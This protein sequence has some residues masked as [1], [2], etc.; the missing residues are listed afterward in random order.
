MKK[1]IVSVLTTSLFLVTGVTSLYAGGGGLSGGALEITQQENK[2]LLEESNSVNSNTRD[3][4]GEIL[5]QETVLDPLAN[6]LRGETIKHISDD[7]TQWIEGG[8]NGDDPLII[9]KPKEFIDEG[10]LTVVRKAISALPESSTYSGAAIEALR[11]EYTQTDLEEKI[12]IL[13]KSSI[14]VDVYNNMC[15]EKKL[16]ELAK[17]RARDAD[18]EYTAEEVTRQKQILYDYACVGDPEDDEH[19]A[20]L[21]DLYH[22]DNSLGGEDAFYNLTVNGD[23]PFSRSEQIKWLVTKDA[24]EEKDRRTRELYGGINAVSE[25]ECTEE[26]TDITGATY[27]SDSVITT[28]SASIQEAYNTSK[29]SIYDYLIGAQGDGYNDNVLG[30]FAESDIFDGFNDGLTTIGT[31]NTSSID[32]ASAPPVEDLRENNTYRLSLIR[33]IT[34][35]LSSYE[36]YLSNLTQVDNAYLGEIAT[37]EDRVTTMKN[38][39]DS[40]GTRGI[41]TVGDSRVTSAYDFYRDRIAKIDGTRSTIASDISKIPAANNLTTTTRAKISASYSSQEISGLYDTYK[42]TVDN[43]EYPTSQSQYTNRLDYDNAS[44]GAKED[45]GP[46]DYLTTCRQIEDAYNSSIYNNNTIYQ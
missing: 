29:Q 9:A 37:Y 15:G 8:F 30:G 28:P 16:T 4:T 2:D 40:L 23:N 43:E 32:T 10:G 6:Q 26:S 14:P 17:N 13:S 21:M 38:C 20:K 7:I 25:R 42:N 1:T 3:Y 19:A 44:K 33:G 22:Q 5:K 34:K 39:Y 24:E 18:G 45:T 41:V 11:N 31:F 36:K 12:S 27:C 35:E 46:E